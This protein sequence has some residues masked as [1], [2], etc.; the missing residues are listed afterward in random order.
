MQ[1]QACTDFKACRLI[2]G[3]GHWVQQ[4]Q[5]QACQQHL[6][7]FVKEHAPVLPALG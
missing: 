1:T 2:D 4:E 3:A 6:L 5:A 7:N